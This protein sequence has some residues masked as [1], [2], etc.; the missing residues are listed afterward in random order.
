MN[1]DAFVKIIGLA[2]TVISYVAYRWL[3]GRCV[4]KYKDQKVGG[5]K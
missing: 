1:F 2:V 3:D 5:R 4:L